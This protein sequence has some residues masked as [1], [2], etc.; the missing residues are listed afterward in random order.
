[1]SNVFR[2]IISGCI[3]WLV[4]F[5]TVTGLFAEEAKPTDTK[6]LCVTATERPAFWA[7]AARRAHVYCQDGGFPVLLP[8]GSALWMFGDTFIVQGK[9]KDGSPNLDGAVSSAVCRVRVTPKGPTAEYLTDAKGCVDFLLPLDKTE[10]W[11]RHRIW[12]AA[13]VHVD[14][15]TYLYYGRV[16]ITEGGPF[17]F[18]GDGGGLA[19]AEKNSWK[20]KRATMPGGP[21][22]LPVSPVCV[23]ARDKNLYLYYLERIGE[24]DSGL[25]LA[26]VP[27]A[28]A[29]KPEAYRF[30]AGD[31]KDTGDRF[32]A[33][34]KEAA[35]LVKEI[36]GQASVVWNEHL[37][38]Y[39]LLHVGGVFNAPRKVYLRTAENCWG[40]WSEPTLVFELPGKLG[41]KF[42]GLIYCAYLHPELFRDDGRVMAFT[43]CLIENDI[44]KFGLANPKLVEIELSD[45]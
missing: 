8:D 29:A 13:G 12:P 21:G 38:R 14:G 37:K 33:L 6:K 43:Y 32:S 15:T 24:L 10:T 34:K 18:K 28:K 22:A 31:T 3:G 11:D 16:V 39:V 2:S 25:Y 42:N 4:I 30:W 19:T 35:P 45:K 9:K 1:M 44:K 36:W 5:A 41:E 20:F 26:R 40:P 27:T 23:I 7:E 17:G